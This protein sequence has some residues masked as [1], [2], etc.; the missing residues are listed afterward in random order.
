MHVTPPV[1]IERHFDS[2]LNNLEGALD[3]DVEGVHQA[4]VATRRLREVLPLVDGDGR[5]A[6]GRIRTAGRHLG[7]VRELDVMSSL[8]DSLG[9]RIPTTTAAELHSASQILRTRRL[10]SRREMVKA[11]ERLNLA[12]LRD[13]TVKDVSHWRWMSRI[14]HGDWATRI[15]ERVLERGDKAAAQAQR[16]HAVYLPNR[17][18]RVRVAIKKF[19]Y[20]L[21]VASETGLWRAETALKDLRRL[22]NMLGDVHDLQ[23]L[24]NTIVELTPVPGDGVPERRSVL[25]A[26]LEHDLAQRYA[27]YARRR[28][29]VVRIAEA[30]ARV[31]HR[32]GQRWR[33]RVPLVA[34]A[35]ITTPVLVESCRRYIADH[36]AFENEAV[37]DKAV[38]EVVPGAVTPVVPAVVRRRAR[39]RAT[40]ES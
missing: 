36:V 6:T 18:H 2:L 31:E 23:M 3:G 16:T 11:L 10:E 15:W 32:R 9:S 19:R 33:R 5:R 8:L 24:A 38:T 21:E 29:R 28:D 25:T 4:R 22:Q 17:A 37:E 14:R 35:V 27:E 39:T 30:C 40:L 12:E 20:A 26:I 13:E 7:K 34:A 1:L